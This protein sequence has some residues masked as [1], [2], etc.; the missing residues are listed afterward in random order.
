MFFGVKISNLFRLFQ[1]TKIEQSD[2]D[3]NRFPGMSEEGAMK[4]EDFS[5]FE[6]AMLNNLDVMTV[7]EA[8]SLVPSLKTLRDRYA[9]RTNASD[10]ELASYD[11]EDLIQNL[12]DDLKRFQQS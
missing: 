10:A 8:L 11:A 7:E 3:L 1:P 9:K 6:I 4:Y 12:L 5:K 2:T